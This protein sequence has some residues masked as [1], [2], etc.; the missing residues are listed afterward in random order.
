MFAKKWNN[1]IGRLTSDQK[2]VGKT[3]ERCQAE[4]DKDERNILTCMI[5]KQTQQT[6]ER[7]YH[8]EINLALVKSYRCTGRLNFILKKHDL[9]Y[10]NSVQSRQQSAWIISS[11]IN[12]NTTTKIYTIYFYKIIYMFN[13]IHYWQIASCCSDRVTVYLRTVCN[14]NPICVVSVWSVCGQCLVSVWRP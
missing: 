11:T 1:I 4:E 3:V 6:E 14:N 12:K 10:R 8:L 7:Q 5:P 9:H 13:Q 2:H